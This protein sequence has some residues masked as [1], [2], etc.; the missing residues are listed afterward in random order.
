MSNKH[1]TPSEKTFPSVLRPIIVNIANKEDF[2]AYEIK[3]KRKPDNGASYMGEIYEVD[4]KGKTKDGDKEIN[5]FVKKSISGVHLD[6]K[7][8]S[9]M[10]L[11]ETFV[12]TDLAKVFKELQDEANV[13]ED[14]KYKMVKCYHCSVTTIILDN[15]A[16]KGFNTC[17]RMNIIELKFAEFCVEELAKFHA[18]SIVLKKKHPVYY[19]KQINHL[20]HPWVETIRNYKEIVEH[21]VNI[22]LNNLVSDYK[23][24]AEK[25]KAVFFEHFLKYLSAEHCTVTCLCHGDYKSDNIL[26]NEIVST[27]VLLG[28]CKTSL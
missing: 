24:T 5:L 18:L 25:Y 14:E 23:K 3:S 16:K 26:K 17:N 20:E 6:D 10:Y 4:I 27:L 9:D 19:E 11:K 22:T 1:I 7:S 28:H 21:F 2:T 12:Y 15:I 13:P 8:I